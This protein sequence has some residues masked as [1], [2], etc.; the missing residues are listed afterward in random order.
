MLIK[1][2]FLKIVRKK[3]TLI[4]MGISLLLTA[5]LFGLPILQFQT[6]NQ[7]GAIKGL[8]A[9]PM[10]KNN[11]KSNMFLSPMNLLKK[12]SHNTKRSL[13]TQPMWDMMAMRN[14]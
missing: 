1:Y 11:I 2:E 7:E 14:F 4:V 5:F 10:K 12:T 6:Y 3:S 8:K 9:L 13:R